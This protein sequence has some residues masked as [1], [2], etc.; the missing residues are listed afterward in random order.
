MIGGRHGLPIIGVAIEL[1][2]RL[3]RSSQRRMCRLV[4]PMCPVES[5]IR[6]VPAHRAEVVN[7]VA[8]ANDEYSALTKR[9]EPRP[10]LE[11]VFKRS[12][13]IDRKLHNGDIRCRKDV[14]KHG[15]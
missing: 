9:C 3:W 14:N 6:R 8:A 11:V 5:E 4:E 10:K 15:P 12:T 7:D 13:R 2:Q 1:R